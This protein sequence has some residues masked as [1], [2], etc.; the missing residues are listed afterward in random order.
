MNR[1]GM[2]GRTNL[3]FIIEINDTQT[4]HIKLMKV[5]VNDKETIPR[6]TVKLTIMSDELVLSGEY[7]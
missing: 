2:I 4:L 5:C 6:K 7:T 1:T 3:S